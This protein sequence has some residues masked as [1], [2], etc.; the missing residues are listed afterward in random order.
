MIFE[1][2]LD[3]FSGRPN[4]AWNLEGQLAEELV[5]RLRGLHR[6]ERQRPSTPPAL[7]Y[8]GLRLTQR[9]AGQ[10]EAWQAP[11]EVY[12]GFVKHG[13]SVYLDESR[14]L[15]RWVL[16]SGGAGV[17]PGLRKEILR[18]IMH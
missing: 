2:V 9:A 16:N 1:V 13:D 8:R 5:R 6:V 4:P 3:V 17:E 7:G 18:E 14:S 11:Y 15:E 10:K 12:G